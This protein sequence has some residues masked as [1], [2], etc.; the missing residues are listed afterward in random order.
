MQKWL[1]P[2]LILTLSLCL[3]QSTA[4]TR[5]VFVCEHG[6]AKS[7]IAAQY[8]EQ[9]AHKNGLAFTAISRGTDPEKQ[10]NEATKK[11]LVKDGFDVSRLSPRRLT[12]TDTEGAAMVISFG[13]DVSPV[14][15][16]GVKVEQ[17]SDTPSVT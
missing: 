8:F 4:P 1:A 10:L 5:I 3:G 9:L 2:A 13:P 14:T 15:K 17:W 11:G 16:P 12:A 7:M 6:S